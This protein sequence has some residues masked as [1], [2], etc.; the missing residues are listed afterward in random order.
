LQV[1]VELSPVIAPQPWERRLVNIRNQVDCCLIVR[2][3]ANQAEIVAARCR[4]RR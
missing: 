4:S 2:V 1:D 3:D